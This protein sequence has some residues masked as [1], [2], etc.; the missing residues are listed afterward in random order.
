MRQ[1]VSALTRKSLADVTRRKGRTVL[2][3]LSIL[4]GVFGLTAINV[5]EDTIISAVTFS[6]D[7]STQPDISFSVQSFNP[8][9]AST[10]AAVPNV[11][12][13][14]F[15][16]V[17]DTSWHLLPAGQV[18]MTIIGYRDPQHVALASFQ[19]TSGRYPGRG[20]I[21]LESGDSVQQ[22]FA[23]GGFI[24]VDTPRGVVQLRILRHQTR[25]GMAHAGTNLGC[26]SSCRLGDR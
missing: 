20:E 14:Q 18:N 19:L 7:E 26:R 23:L 9:L 3:V 17:Y 11:Q 6:Q 16:T 15:Q 1:L 2:V 10:L 13:A 5:T 12:T 8:A 4:I 22:Q 25:I 21:V 24:R